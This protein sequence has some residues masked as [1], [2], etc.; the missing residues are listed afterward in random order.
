MRYLPWLLAGF[1]LVSTAGMLES[2]GDFGA[3]PE[4]RLP[5]YF[6]A[7]A[8]LGA[9]L[10]CFYK[11]YRGF[12]ADLPWAKKEAEADQTPKTPKP[13]SPIEEPAIG[14]SFDVDAAFSRYMT[15]RQG[16][17]KTAPEP[18]GSVKPPAP[19][20]GFGRKGL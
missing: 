6:V 19:R 9:A 16:Q 13:A 11:G 18:M 12:S 17:A 1:G 3:S 7:L 15:T 2:L 20:G 14:E 10:Y 4:M 5:F 8:L